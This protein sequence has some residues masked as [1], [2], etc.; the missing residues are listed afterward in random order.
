MFRTSTLEIGVRIIF[1]FFDN[2]QGSLYL[3]CFAIL[4]LKIKA[5]T[6]PNDIIGWIYRVPCQKEIHYYQIKVMLTRVTR[7]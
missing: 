2:I 5:L 7:S 1:G 4:G 6:L 3:R